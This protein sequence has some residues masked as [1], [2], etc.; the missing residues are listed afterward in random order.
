M[1]ERVGQNYSRAL[2]TGKLSRKEERC[3]EVLWGWVSSGQ[4]RKVK[5]RV[6]RWL[7]W[8]RRCVVMGIERGL[9]NGVPFSLMK[10]MNALSREAVY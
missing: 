10:S 2:D 6:Q 9:R 3:G 5:Q 7:Y 4:L 1:H 8:E